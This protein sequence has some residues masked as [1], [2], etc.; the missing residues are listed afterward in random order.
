M[1]PGSVDW[2]GSQPLGAGMMLLEYVTVVV[3]LAVAVDVTVGAVDVSVSVTVSYETYV[4]CGMVSIFR[5][6]HTQG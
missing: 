5:K 3:S 4:S 2:I 6:A 1:A